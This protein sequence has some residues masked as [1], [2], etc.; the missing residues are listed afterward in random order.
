MADFVLPRRSAVVERLRK[1]IELCRRHHSGSESR[2]QLASAE[3]LEL[4]RQRT[5]TLHQRCLQS[6]TKR[7]GKHRPPAPPAPPPPPG[8]PA[9]PA[10]ADSQPGPAPVTGGT[11]FRNHTAAAAANKSDSPKP[12]GGAGGA[13]PSRTSTLLALQESVKRKLRADASPLNGDQQNGFG[14]GSYPGTKKIRLNGKDGVGLVPVNGSSNGVPAVSPLHQLDVKPAIGDDMLVSGNH[15]M[16]SLGGLKKDSNPDSS[17]QLNG[18][19]DGSHTIPLLKDFKQEPLCDLGCMNPTG[20]SLSQNNMFPDINLNEQEWQELFD[21]L[22][23]SVPDQDIQDLFNEDFEEKK[24]S[25]PTVSSDH[26]SLPDNISVKIELCQPSYEHEQM[27]SPQTRPTSSGPTF[28]SCPMASVSAAP[29][30]TG[31]SQTMPQ[32]PGLPLVAARPVSSVLLPGNAA[33]A[34][35]LNHAQQLQQMA[36]KQQRVQL[37]QKQQ[38]QQTQPNQV[39]NWSAAPAQSPIASAYSREQPSSPSLYQQDFSQ[40]LPMASMPPKSSPKAGSSYLQPNHVGMLSHQPPSSGQTSTSSQ[41]ALFSYANTKRLSHFEMNHNQR[42]AHQNKGTVFTYIQQRHISDEQKPK[43]L[44]TTAM[45]YRPHLQ[46]SQEQTAATVARVSSSIP[47]PGPGPGAQPPPVVI[48]GNHG[49]VAYL[50]SQ[51]AAALKQHQLLMD[52]QKQQEQQQLQLQ[53]H[54]QQILAEQEKQRKQQEQQLQ[55][56]LTRPPPQYQDQQQTPYHVEQLN[57]FQGSSQALPPVGTLAPNANSPRMFSLNPNLRQMGPG[58]NSVPGAG[59]SQPELGLPQ[60][61]NIHSVQQGLY[62]MGSN[63]S[64]M[65]PRPVQGTIG[66]GQHSNQLQRQPSIGHAGAM[67]TGYGQNLLANSNLAQQHNKGPVSQPVSK[68]HPQRLPGSMASQSPTWQHQGLQTMNNQNQASS[69]LVAFNSTST[70]HMQ[71]AQPKMATQQFAQGMPRAGLNPTRPMGSIGSTV[72][73]QI[74]AALGAP[75][76]RTNQPTQ[77]PAP[78]LTQSVADMTTFPA[79][80]QLPTRGNPHCSQGYQVRNANQELSF[81]YGSQSGGNTLQGLA[82]DADP[83]IDSLLKNRITEEWINNLDL[84]F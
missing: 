25:E 51:R 55:R 50:S 26:P 43:D 78:G 59:A 74:I 6:K 20:S 7:A 38:V 14:D 24:D 57:Q 31:V 18:K 16:G 71:T 80:Q 66:N 15:P 9:P 79:G 2:Y 30:V 39:P 53:L 46:L 68:A 12:A 40:K 23:R 10:Q 49:N 63:L 3:C 36:A 4:E 11:G 81:S 27:G 28:S 1:R 42:S 82:S 21:E 22:N 75:Q 33:R 72:G 54:R 83:L 35:E 47:G 45:P 17:V 41:A 52:Q 69:N 19:S 64:Q 29:V 34:M 61:G 37:M 48:P 70:F 13:D 77:Q 65:L 73:G 60:Y 56:H 58:Q 5:F 44:H 32:V 8:P 84:N 62:N 76:T 67:V